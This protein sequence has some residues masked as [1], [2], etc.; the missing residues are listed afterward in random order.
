MLFD[1]SGDGVVSYRETG[2]EGFGSFFL[3]QLG[4]IV[5]CLG[6]EP[7]GFI[8]GRVKPQLKALKLRDPHKNSKGL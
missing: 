5:S 3:A 4:Y 8:S 1:E 2:R 7:L 6:S